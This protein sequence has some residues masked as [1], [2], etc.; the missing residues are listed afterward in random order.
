VNTSN[1]F[2]NIVFLTSKVK[3]QEALM[4]E[5]VSE[6]SLSGDK[7]LQTIRNLQESEK[8]VNA[9]TQKLKHESESVMESLQ[10]LG[11]Q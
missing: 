11:N 6:E 1:E 5:A 8:S 9:I 4:K 3:N 2:E 10:R 7:L